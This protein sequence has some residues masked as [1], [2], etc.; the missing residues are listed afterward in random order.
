[1]LLHR[2]IFVVNHSNVVAI[3][4]RP[5]VIERSEPRETC[6]DRRLP[7]PPVEIHD[8]GMVFLD[9][10]R[11]PHQPI[12][13][14]RG[15]NISEIIVERCARWV[16]KPVMGR[17]VE[18]GVLR[19]VHIRR[20]CAAR[21]QEEIMFDAVRRHAKMQPGGPYRLRQFPGGIAMR[22]HFGH[23]PIAQSAVVHRESVVM[24]GHRHDVFRARFFE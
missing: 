8:I 13:G 7:D 23:R 18:H 24:L 1:M 5:V 11:G 10:F 19:V 22:S 2:V 20:N 6:P 3:F 21:P 4:Q 14:P 17:A 12:V 16:H 9:Q 15:G